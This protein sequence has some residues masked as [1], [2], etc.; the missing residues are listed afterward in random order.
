MG[1]DTL[2]PW[3]ETVYT[4]AAAPPRSMAKTIGVIGLVVDRRPGQL[5]VYPY[6]MIWLPI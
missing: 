3:I 5:D 4:L 1:R 6:Q 2:Y